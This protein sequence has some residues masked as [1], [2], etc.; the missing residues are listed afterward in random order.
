MLQRLGQPWTISRV[1]DASELMSTYSRQWLQIRGRNGGEHSRIWKER[2]KFNMNIFL[3]WF[4]SS[5]YTS[6]GTF[7]VI[8]RVEGRYTTLHSASAKEEKPPV[9]Q[10]D[11]SINMKLGQHDS[12]GWLTGGEICV[13]AVRC[14]RLVPNYFIAARDCWEKVSGITLLC[15]CMCFGPVM[16]LPTVSGLRLHI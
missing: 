12:S 8:Q 14:R 16:S 15:Q 2:T 11:L 9:Y 4:S 5:S 6:G 10:H 13:L 3:D 7:R 1:V